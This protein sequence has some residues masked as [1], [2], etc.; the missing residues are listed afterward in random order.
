ML[1]VVDSSVAV[2]VK[3]LSIPAAPFVELARQLPVVNCRFLVL[4]ALVVL[5]RE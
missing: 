1:A 3:D 5:L 4:L 2:D